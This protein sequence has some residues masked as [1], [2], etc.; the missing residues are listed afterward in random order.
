[1]A[2]QQRTT[3]HGA[4]DDGSSMGKILLICPAFALPGLRLK[5]AKLAR[6]FCAPNVKCLESWRKGAKFDNVTNT[7]AWRRGEKAP[8]DAAPAAKRVQRGAT[9]SDMHASTNL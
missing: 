4:S 9:A 3:P 1:M 7:T 6:F 2:S 8:T 5:G